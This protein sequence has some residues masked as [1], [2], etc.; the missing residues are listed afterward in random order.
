MWQMPHVLYL[1]AGAGMP[2]QYLIDSEQAINTY[3]LLDVTRLI[4]CPAQMPRHARR[5]T[6]WITSLSVCLQA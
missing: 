1:S 4:L 2:S 3:C 6:R 5:W